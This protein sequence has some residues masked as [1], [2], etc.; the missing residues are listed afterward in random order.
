[1]IDGQTINAARHLP[2]HVLDCVDD[3][4]PHCPAAGISALEHDA[5]LGRF[6]ELPMLR[7]DGAVEGD[8][9]RLGDCVGIEPP[10]REAVVVEGQLDLGRSGPLVD[11]DVDETLLCADPVRDRER[12]GSAQLVVVARDVNRGG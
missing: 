9:E 12:S 5:Q 1:M 10:Q 3:P 6:L 11:V 2:L 8:L 7:R 4:K